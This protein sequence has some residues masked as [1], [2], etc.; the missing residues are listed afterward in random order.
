MAMKYL[1]FVH[2]L[3]GFVIQVTEWKYSFPITRY[4]SLSNKVY[5][6]PTCPVFAGPVTI[7]GVYGNNGGVKSTKNSS[8]NGR[9]ML[10]CVSF[11]R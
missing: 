10:Q 2:S 5:F 8:S 6:V 7:Y 3:S 4:S 9:I 1:Q 11:G